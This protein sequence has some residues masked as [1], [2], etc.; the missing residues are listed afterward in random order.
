MKV[1]VLGGDGFC[2]WPPMRSNVPVRVVIAALQ[3]AALQ[4]TLPV[5]R[6]MTLPLI[7]MA[8]IAIHDSAGGGKRRRAVN[9]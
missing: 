6:R 5:R 8:A 1:I 2:G 7:Q 9:V 3:W 4:A